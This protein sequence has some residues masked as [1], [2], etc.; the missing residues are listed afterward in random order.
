MT[1]LICVDLGSANRAV[2]EIVK[3][4]SFAM[5]AISLEMAWLYCLQYARAC[6][7]RNNFGSMTKLGDM[8][9]KFTPWSLVISR[10]LAFIQAKKKL[11]FGKLSLKMM[12][13]AMELA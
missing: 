2:R 3:D 4:S 7:V 12:L 1:G 8:T 11:S 6:E 5:P 13:E 9:R 10:T